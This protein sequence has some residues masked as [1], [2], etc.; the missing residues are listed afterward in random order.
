MV[1]RANYIF[2]AVFR[3]LPL[4]TMIFLWW[5]VYKAREAE[6][7][8]GTIM[9]MS[10]EDMVAYN[11]YM[12]IA[13]GFSSIP[14]T[15]NEISKDI[16][17]GLLNRYLIRPMSYLW[18]QVS[19]RLAHKIVFWNVALFTFPFVFLFM[20]LSHRFFTHVPTGLELLAFVLSLVIAFCLGML[21][22][23]SIGLLAF[24]FLELS[25]F[26]FVI[27]MTEF[28]L[29]G[30]LVPLNILP[31]SMQPFLLHSPFGYEGYWPCAILLGKVPA[32]QLPQVLGLGF[33]WVLVFYGISQVM[34]RSGLKRYSAVGG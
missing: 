32:D 29:S 5:A 18:Y 13:R 6:G 10:F 26:L 31:A 9:G 21:F 22:T 14:G 16:K 33:L 30:H 3:F 34:W 4:V 24:W 27:M 2:G 12:Y 25:G 7:N 8:P 20:N 1:Y 11:A 28:F 17:D 23:F 19:Y 15:M